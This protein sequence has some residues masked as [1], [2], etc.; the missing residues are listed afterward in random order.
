ML[1]NKSGVFVVSKTPSQR[2]N[3]I[4]QKL[5]SLFGE[6]HPFHPL[7]K[8]ASGVLLFAIGDAIWLLQNLPKVEEYYK[9]KVE[10][11][12]RVEKDV[13]YKTFE[14]LLYT[15]L[16]EIRNKFLDLHCYNY[17]FKTREVVFFLKINS[18]QNIKEV[19]SLLE[20]ELARKIKVKKILRYRVDAFQLDDKKTKP[21]SE[22]EKL[23]NLSKDLIGQLLVQNTLNLMLHNMRVLL[24]PLPSITASEKDI[25]N[26]F[27]GSHITLQ[28][29][30]QCDCSQIS[31]FKCG[32]LV[33]IYDRRKTPVAVCFAEKSF[34]SCKECKNKKEILLKHMKSFNI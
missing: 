33:C 10:L 11:D 12:K 14:N 13:L 29:F 20:K 31:S 19:L 17:S 6:I 27:L 5:L 28:E 30:N 18:S 32:D 15:P 26:I 34:D 21:V 8:N 22:F 4:H 2:P 1:K 16:L 3:D 9:I 24:K 23:S 25:Q 7:P